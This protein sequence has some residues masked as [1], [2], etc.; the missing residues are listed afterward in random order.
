MIAQ[1]KFIKNTQFELLKQLQSNTAAKWGLMSAQGM[2]EHLS[3]LYLFA[4][5]KIQRPALH[6]TETMKERYDIFIKGKQSF[7]KNIPIKGLEK[8]LPL[9]YAS[10]EEAIT[11]LEE[12]T[13]AFFAFF[14]ANKDKKTMHPAFGMLNFEDW[15]QI[16]FTHT[17]HHLMQF[18]LID[19]VNNT[20][21]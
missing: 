18:G 8:P 21:A 5:E 10:I 13:T 17:Q 2:V 15:V 1:I 6:D 16:H 4:V 19:E 3:I 11:S 20:E 7:S 9:K 14:E 12:M